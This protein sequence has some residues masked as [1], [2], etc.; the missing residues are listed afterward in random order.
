MMSAGLGD[1]EAGATERYGTGADGLKVWELCMSLPGAS[2]ARGASPFLRESSSQLST[3]VIVTIK[4]PV[5]IRLRQ[6]RI[7]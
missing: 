2:I 4:P 7:L 5:G 6:S 3:M 1:S